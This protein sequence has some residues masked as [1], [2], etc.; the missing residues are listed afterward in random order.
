MNAAIDAI[1]RHRGLVIPNRDCLKVL[2]QR[3][4]TSDRLLP[5]ALSSFIV[6]LCTMFAAWWIAHL[7]LPIGL[8]RGST[9]AATAVAATNEM[10]P[11]FAQALLWNSAVAFILVPLVSLLSLRS[12]SLGHVLVWG[13]FALYGIFLGTNSFSV[14]RDR[15]TE[16]HLAVFLGTGVWEIGAYSLVAAVFATRCRWNQDGWLVGKIERTHTQR[17]HLS[18]VEWLTLTASLMIIIATAYM[19]HLRVA[20]A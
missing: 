15:I 10:L 20:A 1:K 7:F 8:L 2:H 12:L 13:N 11:T 5:R 9:A 16:P 4:L 14:V 19:E 3:A 6:G 18:R 17:A